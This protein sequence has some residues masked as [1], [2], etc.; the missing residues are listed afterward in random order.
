MLAPFTDETAE[1]GR[2]DVMG[3]R[4]LPSLSDSKAHIFN[5]NRIICVYRWE[6]EMRLYSWNYDVSLK[7]LSG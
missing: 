1:A 3:P 5:N 2:G 4:Y 6:T 7:M